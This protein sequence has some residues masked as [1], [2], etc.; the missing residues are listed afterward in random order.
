MIIAAKTVQWR[1]KKK[2]I[3]K[4]IDIR[5]YIVNNADKGEKYGRAHSYRIVKLRRQYDG[6]LEQTTTVLL[7]FFFFHFSVTLPSRGEGKA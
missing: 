1:W 2:K 5:T 3:T 7:V 4:K 6:A